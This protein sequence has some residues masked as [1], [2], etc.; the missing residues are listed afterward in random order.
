MPQH[1]NPVLT[2]TSL[3]A[4]AR[5]WVVNYGGC[6][7]AFCEMVCAA[8]VP[9]VIGFGQ[10]G[11]RSVVIE[12]KTSRS[13]FYA[14][15]KKPH[16]QAPALGMGQFRFY[17]CPAGLLTVADLPER[18]GLIYVNQRGVPKCVHNPY[19]PYG[20][21]CW[22][23][24]FEEYNLRDER[25]LMYSALIRKNLKSTSDEPVNTPE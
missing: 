4:S 11:W 12:C 6:S 20:G 15:R 3:V 19:N 5:R 22:S 13:D 17:C 23:D 24:G 8:E 25:R 2:H 16:R 21:N 9:D 7:L 10:W 14:D 1:T 18:W